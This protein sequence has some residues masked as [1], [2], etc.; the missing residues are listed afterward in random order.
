[1]VHHLVKDYP[2]LV[3]FVFIAGTLSM[4]VTEQ[5]QLKRRLV[6]GLTLKNS[7]LTPAM[8]RSGSTARTKTN[9]LPLSF[10]AVRSKSKMS[11]EINNYCVLIICK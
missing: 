5:R 10:C 6:C 11:S 2:D 1:M 3:L 4:E 9:H 8:L 7:F